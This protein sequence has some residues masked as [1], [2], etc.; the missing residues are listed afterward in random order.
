MTEAPESPGLYRATLGNLPSGLVELSLEGGEVQSLLDNDPT[1]AQKTL[2]VEVQNGLNLEQRNINADRQTMAAVAEAGNGVSVDGPYAD[3]LADQLPDLNYTVDHRRADR[4]VHRPREPLHQD[5][6]LGRADPLRRPDHRRMDHPQGGR[7]GVKQGNPPRSAKS[8]K[9]D[10]NKEKDEREGRAGRAEADSYHRRKDRAM[11]WPR[12]V[13]SLLSSFLRVCLRD[14]FALS[15]LLAIF[16]C[17]RRRSRNERSRVRICRASDPRSPELYPHTRRE[18]RLCPPFHS[19]LP[20]G[21]SPSASS[22]RSGRSPAA[23]GPSWPPRAS[24]RPCWSA[25]ALILAAVLILGCFSNVPVWVRDP[26]RPDRLGLGDRVGRL[27]PPARPAAPQPGPHRP[28]RG[29]AS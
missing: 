7:A 12:Y 6:P 4:P 16:Q 19:P 11:C 20:P 29:G 15:R 8:A 1:A 24:S 5:H 18:H 9:A 17:F 14:F 22:T 2:V 21:S 13:L 3:L 10:A 25:S 28:G 26:R 23:S 27:L